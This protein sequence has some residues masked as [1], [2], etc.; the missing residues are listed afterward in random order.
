V[1]EI[2]HEAG[3]ETEAV[4]D[5]AFQVVETAAVKIIKRIKFI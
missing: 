3:D 1:E 2:D 5:R 4:G